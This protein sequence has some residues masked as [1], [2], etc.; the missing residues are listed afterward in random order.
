VRCGPCGLS[1]TVPKYDVADICPV[2][3]SV[4]PSHRGPP[5]GGHT[6]RGVMTQPMS[7]RSSLLWAGELSVH[8]RRWVRAHW[9]MTLVLSAIS[10]AVGWVWNMYVMAVVLEGSVPEPGSDTATMAE[11]HDGNALFWLL[12]FSV[13]GGLFTYAWSRGWRLFW[14]DVASLPRRFGAALSTSPAATF[15]MLLW[16]ASI[17][18]IIST[19]ISTAVSLAL[20]LVLLALAG[21]PVGVILNFAL[22]RAWR[23]LSGIVAPDAGRRLGGFV[24]PAVV[25]VGEAK[26]GSASK[27]KSR[28]AR[29]SRVNCAR[30]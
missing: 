11:G 19:L 8:W 14:S 28:S 27:R 26:R 18:L 15:A 4:H 1:D 5:L 10:F 17:S 3:Y 7:Y 29:P 16:G 21:T 24:S 9:R 6:D 13:L 20:G 2:P 12:L 22:V 30:R 25:T 23:G